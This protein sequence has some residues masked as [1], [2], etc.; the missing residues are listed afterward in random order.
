[1]LHKA[2]N[3]VSYD[4]GKACAKSN[5]LILQTSDGR[6]S[7]SYSR[8]LDA[9]QGTSLAYAA[10]WGFHY[11]RWD[12]LAKGRQ[13]WHATYNRIYL[14]H[15]L[16]QQGRF[17]WVLFLDP[18]AVL[19]DPRLSVEDLLDERYA[20]LG[21][22]GG[23]DPT[24][25]WDINLGV[26]FFNLRHPEFGSVIKG[27]TAAIDNVASWTLERGGGTD[28]Y[29][30]MGQGPRVKDDQ[31]MLHDVLSKHPKGKTLVKRFFGGDDALLFNYNKGKYG[32]HLI[33]ADNRDQD[34][35]FVELLQLKA[36]FLKT[37]GEMEEERVVRGRTQQLGRLMQQNKFAEALAGIDELIADV[38]SDRIRE[39]LKRSRQQIATRAETHTAEERRQE[40]LAARAGR[41]QA[42]TVAGLLDVAFLL[43]K[44]RRAEAATV[45]E[46]LIE[47][48][49][50]PAV[51]GKLEAALVRLRAAAEP[52]AD[53]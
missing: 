18:D 6:P 22:Q 40:E 7:S 50:T 23:D 35:R 12:G 42:E 47:D 44:G 43:E 4:C 25:F 26:G 21:C 17:D 38:K 51:T 34:A 45:L 46:R 49:K 9:L 36:D 2:R 33:R 11:L 5:L 8:M 31:Q 15:A 37:L 48:S 27:W 52:V 30:A 41:L 14:L 1:M 32:A 28:A 19:R 16:H 29:V 20:V 3:Y 24:Q 13:A 53:E 39:G 10:Q